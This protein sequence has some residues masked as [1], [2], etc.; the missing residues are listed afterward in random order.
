MT[1]YCHNSIELYPGS[2]IIKFGS[3]HRPLRTAAEDIA[4]LIYPILIRT[5][6]I[7]MGCYPALLLLFG[8]P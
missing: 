7:S 3:S 5:I 2:S 4:E 1:C 8:F 6:D